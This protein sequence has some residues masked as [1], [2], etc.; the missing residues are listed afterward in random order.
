MGH[1]VSRRCALALTVGEKM[2]EYLTALQMSFVCFDAVCA[3]D[4]LFSTC[5]LVLVS[6]DS[7]TV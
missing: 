5:L 2:E 4:F 1:P 6:Q 7:L 3:S